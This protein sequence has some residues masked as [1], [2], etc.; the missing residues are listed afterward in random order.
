MIDRL[1]RAVLT[2][3]ILFFMEVEKWKPPKSSQEQLRALQY[4]IL[5]YLL[6][7]WRDILMGEGSLWG[8]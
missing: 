3:P 2:D 4:V 8:Q 1:M 5:V 7:V 6:F